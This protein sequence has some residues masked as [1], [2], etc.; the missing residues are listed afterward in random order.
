[1]LLA[2]RFSLAF[3]SEKRELSAYV[4]TVGKNGPK[5]A[6]NETG[7]NLPGFG[8]RG[9]GGILVRNAT[10]AQFAGFL[11]S[12]ILDRP[13]VDQTGLAEKY[14]FTLTWRPDQL[15]TPGP[16]APPLPADIES[17]SDLFTAFQEQLGLK[18]EAV[19][20]PVEVLVI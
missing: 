9:P 10:M 15:P 7:G 17:R 19:K 2:E 4:I 5:L 13:V 8:G 6:K 18:L 3:H 11:Q 16:N 20:T 12:R 1:K 14:D